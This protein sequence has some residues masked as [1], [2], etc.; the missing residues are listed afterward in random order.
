MWIVKGFLLCIWLVSF[1]TLAYL[2]LIL[3]RRVPAGTAIGV[4][5]FKSLLV[6]NP[7]WWFSMA[8]CFAIG[9]L[10]TRSWPGKPILWIALVVTE[11]FPVGLLVLFFALVSRNREMIERMSK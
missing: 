7:Y 3:F 4:D 6:L 10:V 9:I 2:Y 8:A 11:L 1:G 5:V